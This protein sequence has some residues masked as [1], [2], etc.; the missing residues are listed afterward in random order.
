MATRRKPPPANAAG[1]DPPVTA[2][3]DDRTEQALARSREIREKGRPQMQAA[4]ERV[5]AARG[6]RAGPKVRSLPVVQEPAV[7]LV[8]ASE[9]IERSM[10]A[11]ARLAAVAAD[12]VQT[13]EA[14]AHVHDKLALHDSRR[15]A[16][17]RRTADDARQAARR[18]REIQAKAARSDPR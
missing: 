2:G 17:Y 18:A 8:D 10:Q 4:R 14:V 1:D 15:A 6:R 7:G 16:Q 13:E 3:L 9:Q 12:L 11:R 5:A